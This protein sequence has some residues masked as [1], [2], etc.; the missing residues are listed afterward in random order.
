MSFNNISNIESNTISSVTPTSP[1][2]KIVALILCIF[3]GYL[4]VHQFYAG[5]IGI[6]ILYILTGGLFG[7]AWIVDI[8]RILIGKFPDKNGLL[9]K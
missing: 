7:I 2:S 3:F 8:I 6:G 5:K 9:L 4:G 1:K